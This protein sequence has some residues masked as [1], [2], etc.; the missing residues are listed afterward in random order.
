[1]DAERESVKPV[2]E[3]KVARVRVCASVVHGHLLGVCV[4][5]LLELRR[6]AAYAGHARALRA[7]AKRA[8]ALGSAATARS[9]N[10]AK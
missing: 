9:S 2:W 6:Q 7:F 3:H 8:T 4:I 10:A 5:K 1:M